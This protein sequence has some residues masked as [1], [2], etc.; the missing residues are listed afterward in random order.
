[1]HCKIFLE[2]T[3]M[4]NKSVSCQ[5][6]YKHRYQW[7]RIEANQPLTC[8]R[9]WWQRTK[10]I[11]S[12]T[13][14]SDLYKEEQQQTTSIQSCVSQALGNVTKVN[15][16]GKRMVNLKK[17]KIFCSTK[18]NIM[19]KGKSQNGKR[20]LQH[21][22]LTKDPHQGHRKCQQFNPNTNRQESRQGLT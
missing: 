1:M 5:Y 10:D 8:Y 11:T 3:V 22:K 15:N 12:G 16:V 20:S 13:R 19:R 7:T 14:K 4:I 9:W 17:C 18:V 6:E 21:I 2:N